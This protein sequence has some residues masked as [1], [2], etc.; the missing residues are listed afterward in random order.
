MS[1]HFPIL[2]QLLTSMIPSLIRCFLATEPDMSIFHTTDRAQRSLLMCQYFACELPSFSYYFSNS[3]YQPLIYIK[4]FHGVCV[5]LVFVLQIRLFV[6]QIEA[7][8]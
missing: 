6:V 8:A 1:I 7:K 4:L 3:N 5:V 2:G